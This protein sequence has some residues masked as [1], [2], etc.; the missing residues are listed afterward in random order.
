VSLDTFN[1]VASGVTDVVSMCLHSI[2]FDSEGV[3]LCRE[4]TISIVQ[5]ATRKHCFIL[6]VQG[7]GAKDPMVI[8][9]RTVLED[10]RVTKIIHDCRM[11][12]DALLHILS[13]RL[14]NVHDTTCWHSA[15]TN[16]ENRNL[17]DVLTHNGLQPNTHRNSSIYK[18]NHAF[19]AERPLT[20]C[21]LEWAAG[22]VSMLFALY[23]KQL[24]TVEFS[25]AAQELRGKATTLSQA[26]VTFACS[27]RVE[28]ISVDKSHIGSFIGKGGS[29]I[30]RFIVSNVF[31]ILLFDILFQ[32]ACTKFEQHIQL[33]LQHRL[34]EQTGMLIYSR[35][36]RSEHRFMV[37]YDDDSSLAIV[38]S[39]VVP[40]RKP[41]SED[42]SWY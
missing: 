16:D 12:S 36:K 14:T 4:G 5:L 23:D 26:S 37:F 19:W 11:D 27:A 34:S 9:L 31:N 38:R 7:K 15:I 39:A 35:G 30:R 2:V 13:I 21:M 40:P 1:I 3:D 10:E 22:D 29:S 20:D 18:N 41:S 33:F 17:N 42:S 25:P 28:W 24:Q 8:W 6:D 32:W